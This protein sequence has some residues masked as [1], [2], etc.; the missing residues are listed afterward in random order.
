LS[1]GFATIST[2]ITICLRTELGAT[3]DGDF[4]AFLQDFLTTSWLPGPN[5]S[6]SH[7]VWRQEV[8]MKLFA[9]AS[10]LALIGSWTVPCVEAQSA[11]DEGRPVL[12]SMTQALN[13]ATVPPIAKTVSFPDLDSALPF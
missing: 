4:S 1:Q 12:T 7:S 13:Q 8:S 5:L 3:A 11:F 6:A 9:V 10:T 2:A